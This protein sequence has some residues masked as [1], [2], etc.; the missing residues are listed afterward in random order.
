M[1]SP[2]MLQEQEEHAITPRPP[3]YLL[4][5]DYFFIVLRRWPFAL[6]GFAVG[7]GAA[8]LV[9]LYSERVYESSCAVLVERYGAPF[10]DGTGVTGQTGDWLSTEAKLITSD[11][12]LSDAALM[13]GAGVTSVSLARDLSVERFRSTSVLQVRFRSKDP[14]FAKRAVEQVAEAYRKHF[15]RRTKSLSE[16][17]LEEMR[18]EEPRL[19]KAMLDAEKKRI[20]EQRRLGVFSLDAPQAAANQRIEAL[21]QSVTKL[22]GVFPKYVPKSFNY[23]ITI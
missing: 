12:V 15:E 21:S 6:F 20:E 3:G 19:E 9:Y 2:G 1:N 16:R 22:I 13:L 14:V 23:I 18:E 17:R 7:L 4:I 11:R 10:R 8:A 5:L